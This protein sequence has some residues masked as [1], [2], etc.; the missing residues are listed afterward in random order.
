M[1]DPFRVL[2]IDDRVSEI[3]GLRLAAAVLCLIGVV[4]LAVSHPPWWALAL[5]PLGLFVSLFW[6]R[7]FRAAKG[8]RGGVRGHIDLRPEALHLVT[9]EGTE[10]LAWTQIAGIEADEDRVAV[11]IDRREGA[12]PVWVEPTYGGLGLH[13]LEEVIRAAREASPSHGG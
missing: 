11:R 9:R 12:A 8:S 3:A 13:E 7:R 4:W 1:A 2:P 5:V 10:I 6:F